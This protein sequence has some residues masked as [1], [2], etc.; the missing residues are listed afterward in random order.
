MSEKGKHALREKFAGFRKRTKVAIVAALVLPLVA[1]GAVTANAIT[2]EQ[3]GGGTNLS[4]WFD[5][6]V[7]PNG[8][9]VR[10]ILQSGTCGG[11]SIHYRWPGSE[12][13]LF[14]AVGEDGQDG[15]DGAPGAD[16]VS[17]YEVVANEVTWEANSTGNVTTAT[18]PDGKVAVGGGFDS[19]DADAPVALKGS[20]FTGVTEISEDVWGATGW[21][22]R[23][24]GQDTNHQLAAWVSC[25]AVADSATE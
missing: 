6:C 16:G 2:T 8:K 14:D 20:G 11:G 1:A 10:F 7:S 15:D 21:E 5:V 12:N 25:A 9:D 22:V 3:Q 19:D 18:C 13:K 4:S 17:G 23:G 24:D